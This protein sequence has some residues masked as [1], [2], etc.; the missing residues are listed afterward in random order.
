MVLKYVLLIG[1]AI[2][3]SVVLVMLKQ[4][5][6]GE[7]LR[8][9]TLESADV[10]DDNTRPGYAETLIPSESPRRRLP[11]A[12]IGGC[13]KCGTRALLWMLSF[14]PAVVN[15]GP[16]TH[17]F[18]KDE[19]YHKGLD[20]YL[21]FFPPRRQDQIG[22]EKTPGYWFADKAP[23]RIYK[24]NRAMKLIFIVCEPV[25]KAISR[26]SQTG[27][28]SHEFSERILYSRNNS[29]NPMSSAVRE[30]IYY[31]HLQKWLAWFPLNQMHFVNGDHFKVDPVS[32]IRQVETFLKIPHY[33][34]GKIVVYDKTKGFYCV[35]K[36]DIKCLGD[37]KGI[38]HQKVP[39]E[40]KQKLADFY[41]PLNQKFLHAIGRTFFWNIWS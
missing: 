17:F 30:G 14:H 35:V 21:D 34:N 40:I 25:L 37:D 41:K 13:A 11:N 39:P 2:N 6:G 9:V 5:S 31:L 16:E 24:M 18:D 29:V 20:W 22:I 7:S 10:I 36:G 15:A 12:I 4:R 27:Y 38:P 8:S 1:A 26:F 33:V 3:L 32:E 28:R 23:Q 19:N